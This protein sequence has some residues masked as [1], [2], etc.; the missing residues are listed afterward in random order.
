[1]TPIER[2]KVAWKALSIEQRAAKLDMTPS[3]YVMDQAGGIF[4]CGLFGIGFLSIIFAL[5]MH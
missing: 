1:M 4:L 2:D 3:E 5:F